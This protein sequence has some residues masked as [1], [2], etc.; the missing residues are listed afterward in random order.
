[1]RILF[2]LLILAISVNTYA[3]DDYSADSKKFI[4]WV[5]GVNITRGYKNISDKGAGKVS[6]GVKEN[7][8]GK[9]DGKVVSLGDSG[10]VVLTF[11]IPLA[12]GNGPDFAV[13][14]NGAM[15][16]TKP[17][18]ELAFV[19]VSSNGEDFFRFPALSLAP[20]APQTAS[21]DGTDPALI[22]NL[23]GKTLA[24]VGT[25]FDLEELRSVSGLD[26]NNI[27]HIKLIDVIGAVSGDYIS[28]DSKGNKIN[29]PYPT[30]FES[31][32][33]D[34][35]AVGV[36]NNRKSTDRPPV[37]LKNI[38]DIEFNVSDKEMRVDLKT[39]FSDPDGDVIQYSVES[40]IPD[41]DCL[42][43][44]IEESEL[45]VKCNEI[46]SSA[47]TVISV[48]ATTKYAT[49]TTTFIVKV[50]KPQVLDINASKTSLI[51]VYPNPVSDEVRFK[52]DGYIT[53][54][55]YT[56]F[57]YDQ[58]GRL[59]FAS[60]SDSEDVVLNISEFNPGLYFYRVVYR[61]VIYTGKIV[62]Q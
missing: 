19:E 60:E 17:F 2:I 8:T 50:T 10:V 56:L 29:D 34:L 42:D 1:M 15:Y 40:E 61:S 11:D 37:V 44:T 6:Y 14:E 36:I 13:F 48:K 55:C 27:T 3:Q 49:A 33:F 38:T 5:S 7:A 39:I 45:V 35:D 4:T 20:D 47:E 58:S 21:F 16:G 53:G 25:P 32:G 18:L 54:T 43:I 9:A 46:V 31:G 52:I 12:N 23:A 51:L 41:I 57:L 30:P 59:V 26:V 22:T 24:D 28:Y 62:K